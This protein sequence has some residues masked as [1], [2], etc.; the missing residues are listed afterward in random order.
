MGSF[1]EASARAGSVRISGQETVIDYHT[2]G[3]DRRSGRQVVVEDTALGVA[4]RR[5]GHGRARPARTGR[6]LNLLEMAVK[7][8]GTPMEYTGRQIVTPL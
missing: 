2:S 1:E 4:C 8:I 5:P 7:T 3:V 6:A